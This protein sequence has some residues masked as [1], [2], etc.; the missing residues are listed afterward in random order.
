MQDM[1]F[2]G[3]DAY[4]KLAIGWEKPYVFDASDY[5]VGDEFEIDISDSQS[6]G[7]LIMLTPKFASG[8]TMTSGLTTTFASLLSDANHL[9]MRSKIG[10]RCHFAAKVGTAHTKSVAVW[11]HFNSGRQFSCESS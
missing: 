1:S 7:D 6:S 8:F 2:G 4:S 11:P 5:S 9:D 3:H 10:I